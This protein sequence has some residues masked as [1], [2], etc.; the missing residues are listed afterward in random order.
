MY[1]H[2]NLHGIFAWKS[3]ITDGAFIWLFASMGSHMCV[4]VYFVRKSG[5]TDGAFIRFFT[6]MGSHV[7]V[8]VSLLRKLDT[9]GCALIRLFASM[10]S[11]VYFRVLFPWKARTT[12][13]AF[14]WS[15]N[16]MYL[17][18]PVQIL[19]SGNIIPPNVRG[20]RCKGVRTVL[21]VQ[22][23]MFFQFVSKNKHSM[24]YNASIRFSHSVRH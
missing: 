2:V 12:S 20:A 9:T 5:I 13:N 8:Q 18:V 17:M 11:H 3:I 1:P 21:N 14:V 10:G 19:S 16:S 23:K 4:H 6:G 24:A 22:S 7:S 15:L